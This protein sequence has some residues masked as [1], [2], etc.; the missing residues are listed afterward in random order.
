MYF[1]LNNYG[2]T[3]IQMDV[4]TLLNGSKSHALSVVTHCPDILQTKTSDLHW[5]E[6]LYGNQVD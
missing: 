5:V 6:T 2:Q 1:I 3:N 4:K